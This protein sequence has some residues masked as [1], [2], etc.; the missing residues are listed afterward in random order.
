MTMEKITLKI[1][2][3]PGTRFQ[4]EVIGKMMETFAT[5]THSTKAQHKGNVVVTQVV[6]PY[7]KKL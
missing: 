1:E 5:V 6:N 2:V 7:E 4:G 3:T